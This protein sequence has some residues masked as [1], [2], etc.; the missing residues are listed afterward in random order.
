MIT[1]TPTIVDDYVD[2]EGTTLH[3]R[4]IGPTGGT[5]IVLIHG[6]MGH[7]REWDVVTGRLGMR[8]RVVAIELRGHGDSDWAPPYTVDRMA[9]D[10]ASAI[11]TIGLGRVVLVGHS[12]GGLVSMVLAA[13]RPELVDG[14]VILDAVPGILGSDFALEAPVWLAEMAEAR[15]S[16]I[17]EALVDWSEN[18]FARPELLRHYLEHA[19]VRTPDGGLRYGFDAAGLASWFP[20]LATEHSLWE[21]V[22]RIVA[23]TVLVR[24]EHSPF[25][26]AAAA[27]EMVRRLASGTT[28][29]IEGVGH[30]LGVEAPEAVADLLAPLVDGFERP[31]S[32]G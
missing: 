29:V 7:A 12:L 31:A 17:D 3:Y 30:D 32:G 22:E 24:G 15:F 20:H 16:S 27:N 1:T 6:V 26:S 14:V 19:L 25:V 5:P 11:E 4:D 21:A 2:V 10:V 28:A 13:R 8:N 23:P 18:P 9:E